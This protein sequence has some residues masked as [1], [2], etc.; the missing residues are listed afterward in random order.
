MAQVSVAA[1]AFDFRAGLPEAAVHVF[2]D[3]FLRQRLI[4]TGP[5]R[6]GVE[7]RFRI[8]QGG[9]AAD[10]GKNAVVV[11]IPVLACE[12]DF[13]IGLAGHVELLRV[14]LLAP[15]GIG[16][17]DLR[18]FHDTLFLARRIEIDDANRLGAALSSCLPRVQK[19]PIAARN[20]GQKT[21]T[22]RFI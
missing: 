17:D 7:F 10:T 6:A 15:F 20:R 2:G 9:S 1:S 13:G 4:E 16:F 19:T 12:G 18:N 5:S 22:G 11:Q 21:P 14:E 8:E 3:I